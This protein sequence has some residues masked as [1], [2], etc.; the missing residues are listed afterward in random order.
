LEEEMRERIAKEFGFQEHQVKAILEA[1]ENPTVYQPESSSSANA[2]TKSKESDIPGNTVLSPP[3][4][5]GYDCEICN[6]NFPDF[7]E[8]NNHMSFH[9]PPRMYHCTVCNAGYDQKDQLQRHIQHY[10]PGM[11]AGPAI[12]RATIERAAR[13]H[14][15]QRDTPIQPHVGRGKQ[16]AQM[17]STKAAQEQS[18]IA[19][20]KRSLT[21]RT[22]G[23]Q[24]NP[25]REEFTETSSKHGL[26]ML[27]AGT[28]AEARK[29]S[30]EGVKHIK[31]SDWQ[32]WE[33]RL[34]EEQ[35]TESSAVRYDQQDRRTQQG[36][37][38]V[39]PSEPKPRSPRD[40]P[41]DFVSGPKTFAE[42]GIDPPKNDDECVGLPDARA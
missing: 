33:S 6:K 19:S 23:D 4:S 40:A 17:D 25:T 9:N 5:V 26:P 16:R 1:G 31:D 30:E 8:L 29:G 27:D 41:L 35:S 36:G 11:D 14:S 24:T 18:A 38:G 12:E 3:A 42:M 2:G 13:E 37:S 32:D 7:L 39:P 20:Y 22:T 21:R 34:T 10:H 28:V 15:L